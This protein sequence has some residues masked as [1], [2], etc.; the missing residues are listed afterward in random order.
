M[1]RGLRVSDQRC[2]HGEQVLVPIVVEASDVDEAVSVVSEA[3][4]VE[5]PASSA[6]K[7]Y[8]SLT[9]VLVKPLTVHTVHGLLVCDS[10]REVYPVRVHSD[11]SHAPQRTSH[12]GIESSHGSTLTLFE[13][14][15]MEAHRND[16][17]SLVLSVQCHAFIGAAHLAVVDDRR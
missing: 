6:E 14:D 10:R 9:G 8:V 7:D 15:G 13:R 16:L 2:L 1:H 5:D 17:S 11:R 4:V 12:L 3:S